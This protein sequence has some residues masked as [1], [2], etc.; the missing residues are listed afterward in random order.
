MKAKIIAELNYRLIEYDDAISF[1]FSHKGEI[2]DYLAIA[3]RLSESR[4]GRLALS[5]LD[6]ID[7]YSKEELKIE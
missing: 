4:K 5:I 3:L 1:D 7:A 6:A 2:E